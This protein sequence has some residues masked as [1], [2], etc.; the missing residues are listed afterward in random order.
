MPNRSAGYSRVP[1]VGALG[2]NRSAGLVNVCALRCRRL[3][4]F[5]PSSYNSAR[6][7]A[8]LLLK[9]T[10]AVAAAATGQRGYK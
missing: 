8:R 2:P 3:R 6:N 1:L 4:L 7:H 10:A 9:S 5:I